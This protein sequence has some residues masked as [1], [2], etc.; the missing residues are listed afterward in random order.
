MSDH[1]SPL[2]WRP[3][4]DSRGHLEFHADGD[5]VWWE[6][7]DRAYTVHRDHRPGDEAPDVF[8]ACERGE[9]AIAIPGKYRSLGIAQRAAQR[10]HDKKGVQ[11]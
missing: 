11:P 6:T 7:L 1:S 9:L 2:Q 8:F 5:P 10:W 3:G 4:R